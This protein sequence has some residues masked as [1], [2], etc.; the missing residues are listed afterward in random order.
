M[1]LKKWTLAL[2]LVGLVS[3]ESFC[4]ETL[5]DCKELNNEHYKELYIDRPQIAEMVFSEKMETSFCFDPSL[6][7]EKKELIEDFK[8]LDAIG[9]IDKNNCL[10]EKNRNEGNEA[11]VSS[12]IK[13]NLA[14]SLNVYATQNPKTKEVN[15]VYTNSESKRFVDTALS[16]KDK[17]QIAGYSATAIAL[18][19]LVSE[20]AY[21]GQADKRSHWIMGASI[22]GLTTGATY[23]VLETAGVGDKLNLSKSTKKKLIMLSGPIMG[24]IAGILKEAYD[25]KHRNKH[26]VDVHDAAATSLGAGGLMFTVTFA[27]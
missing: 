13:K 18:G 14:G 17:W 11:L 1:H 26:T 21:K 7:S 24:T 20:T 9:L 10:I 22:S 23:L 27:L 15:L 6:H 2:T 4:A 19:A 16:S 12:F 8:M 3:N 5:G 25:S